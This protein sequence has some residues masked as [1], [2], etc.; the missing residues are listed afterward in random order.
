MKAILNL[1]TDLSKEERAEAIKNCQEIL[2]VFQNS[3]YDKGK[4]KG[5]FSNL[6]ISKAQA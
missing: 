4:T 5:I 2:A 1:R 3:A 6:D